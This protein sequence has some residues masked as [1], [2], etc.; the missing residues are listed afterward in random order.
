MYVCI[1]VRIYIYIYIYITTG[2]Q[3]QWHHYCLH[4][5]A[6]ICIKNHCIS[7]H[8]K[9]TLLKSCFS[10]MPRIPKTILRHFLRLIL[11]VCRRFPTLYSYTG[12]RRHPAH[13]QQPWSS[14]THLASSPSPMCMCVCVCVCLH[15]YMYIYIYTYI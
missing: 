14:S 7:S 3:E 15:I 2:G 9:L 10:C 5:R 8:T 13:W 12:S 4:F 6:L 1:S 11:L